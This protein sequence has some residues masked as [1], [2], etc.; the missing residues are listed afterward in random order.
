M[1]TFQTRSAESTSVLYSLQKER[2]GN[3][4]AGPGWL[5]LSKVI[6]GR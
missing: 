4:N 5:G 2:L 3:L 6:Q 1:A